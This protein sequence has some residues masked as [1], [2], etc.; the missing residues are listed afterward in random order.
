MNTLSDKEFREIEHYIRER[1]GLNLEKKKYLIESKLGLEVERSGSDSFAEYWEKVRNDASGI[2]ERRMMNLLTTNYTYFCREEQ[3]FK[4]LRERALLTLPADR[5]RTLRVW[6]AGCS[7]GQ[8]CY[9]IAMALSDC[10]ASG[11]LR[12]PFSILGSDL[13]ETAIEAARLGQY[14]GADY[15]RLPLSWQTLY[16]EILTE[17]RFQ[18]KES[19]K[20]HVS[21][22]RQN[23]MSDFFMTPTYDIIFC[24][25]VLIYFHAKERAELVKRLTAAL[26]PGGYL[27]IGH[28]ESLLSI[29]NSLR[30]IQPAVYRKPEAKK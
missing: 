27:L 19:L 2:L 25:N 30:Y 10:Q 18:V 5:S 13:S 4:F 28:T 26:L 1:Y 23:L 3:H 16:C 9:T 20:E 11:V 21:F 6:S 14:G 29:P 12:G 24:R 17:G 15:A 22:E 8:E 7:T